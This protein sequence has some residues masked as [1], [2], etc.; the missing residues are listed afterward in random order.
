VG[1]RSLANSQARVE[2][3]TA[4]SLKASVKVAATA[5]PLS[6][7]RVEVEPVAPWLKASVVVPPASAPTSKAVVGEES[8]VIAGWEKSG[9]RSVN[10]F[11]QLIYSMLVFSNFQG[12]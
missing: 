9:I 1:L 8:K 2:E 12:H 3:V 5:A 11:I 4:P 7:A 10:S 6:K